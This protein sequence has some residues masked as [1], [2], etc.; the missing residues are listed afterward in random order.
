[1]LRLQQIQPFWL[2]NLDWWPKARPAAITGIAQTAENT[3][4]D[5]MAELLRLVYRRDVGA[6]PE[7]SWRADGRELIESGIVEPRGLQRNLLDPEL[8]ALGEKEIKEGGELGLGLGD[9]GGA[10][11][12]SGSDSDSSLDLPYLGQDI[13]M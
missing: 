13:S 1:M 3:D 8:R 9:G 11:G 7:K 4:A 5:T 6:G 2:R 12:N 10:G